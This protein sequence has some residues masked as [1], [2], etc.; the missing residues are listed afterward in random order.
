MRAA[1]YQAGTDSELRWA[2]S[3][4]KDGDVICMRPGV[5]LI[6]SPLVVKVGV[7]IRSAGAPAV[8]GGATVI[9]GWSF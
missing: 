7:I 4:A 2:L 9:Q 3:G 5:C 1:T 6:E 8:V